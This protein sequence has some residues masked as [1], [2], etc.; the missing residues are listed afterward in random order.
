MSLVSTGDQ[1]LSQ[2]HGLYG[3]ICLGAGIAIE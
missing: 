2:S 1:Q 3:G